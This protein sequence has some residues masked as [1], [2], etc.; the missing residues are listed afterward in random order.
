[1]TGR[2]QTVVKQSSAF[3]DL[4]GIRALAVSSPKRYAD[5]LGIFGKVVADECLRLRN[6]SGRVYLFS[7]CLFA[8]ATDIDA[9]VD[10]VRSLRERLAAQDIY[11]KGALAFGALAAEDAVRLTSISPQSLAERRKILSGYYF[12]EHAASLFGQEQALKGIGLQVD[13]GVA[14]NETVLGLYLDAEPGLKPKC[15]RD[16]RYSAKFFEDEEGLLQAMLRS[17]GKSKS[18]SKRLGRL[19]VTPFVSMIRSYP[20]AK[21]ARGVTADPHRLPGLICSDLFEKV[22]G[23][24]TG[25]EFVLLAL[26]DRAWMTSA[27]EEV[28][29]SVRRRKRVL[30]K[31]GQCP[32]GFLRHEVYETCW[33]GVAEVMVRGDEAERQLAVQ[34]RELRLRGFSLEQ[35][36]KE[37]TRL[38][39][40]SGRGKT[41]WTAAA[42]RILLA[43][44]R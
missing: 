8:E 37:F 42:V 19:Y 25:F 41:S 27:F 23:D 31:L 38:R 2:R 30:G 35:V 4:V 26:L 1:M 12:G 13:E 7:D 36:A 17:F 9:L 32:N 3:L 14:A 16:L 6:A 43:S 40:L 11:L 18:H 20:D 22:F 39:V 34:A 29:R 33:H 5:T 44:E 24:V 21:L 15:F 28:W 10:F